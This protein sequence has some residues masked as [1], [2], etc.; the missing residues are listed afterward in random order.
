MSHPPSE[1]VEALAS[2]RRPLVIGHVTPDVD[3][4]GSMLGL[5]RAMPSGGAA[6]ALSARPASQ[7]LRFLLELAGGMPVA[8]AARIAETDLFVVVDTASTARVNI[9][10]G[11]QAIADRAVANI[12]H[13]ITNPDFGRFN[14][15]VATASSTSEM[16]HRLI[17]AAGWKIDAITA[18]LL[19]AGLQSDTGGFSL[20]NATADAFE[21]AAALI[22]DGADIE[23]VSARLLRSQEPHE[24]A[25]MRVV[26]HNTRVVADGRIAYSTLSHEEITAAGCSPDDIDDQVS[27]PRSLS[28]IRVAMLFSE[29]D[30]GLI[31]INFRGEEGTP[32]LPLAQA[33]G[34]G[35]HTYSA[36]ARIR[37]EMT[38]VVDR[39]LKEAAAAVGTPA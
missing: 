27:I 23:R 8:D 15:V 22:R 28:R 10:G 31:R 36:G 32:V 25:L 20:P 29:A 35:G 26:Y 19:F 17:R 5:A 13:H 39:V 4:L 34:G 30:R 14:W 6:I 24:F 9:P 1:L 7:K 38:G 3:A 2:A 11:W 21:T 18:S 12:D 37:G 33:L 16:V